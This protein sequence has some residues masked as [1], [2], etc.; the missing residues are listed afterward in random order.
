MATGLA[1]LGILA[2]CFSTVHDYIGIIG[3]IACFLTG[4]VTA[5]PVAL[6]LL[7]AHAEWT[8]FGRLIGGMVLIYIMQ[9][10][11]AVFEWKSRK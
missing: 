7:L 5:I 2:A 3:V 4:I 8:M 9:L 6:I 11:A 10:L 1:A